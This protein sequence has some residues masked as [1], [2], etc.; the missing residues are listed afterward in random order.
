MRKNRDPIGIIG[1]EIGIS[2]ELVTAVSVEAGAI[3]NAQ[4][5]NPGYNVLKNAV[6]ILPISTS[7]E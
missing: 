7:V 1:T 2:S 5:A 3:S 4:A 6:Q